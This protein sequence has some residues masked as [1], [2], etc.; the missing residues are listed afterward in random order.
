MSRIRTAVILAAG[1][2]SR[3]RDMAPLKPLCPVAGKPLI[4]HALDGLATAG[5]SRAIVILGYGGDEI[6]RHLARRHGRL[7]LEAARTPDWL[8]PNGVSVLAAAPLLAGE[9]AVLAMCDHLVTPDLYARL[10]YAGTGG[11]LRLGIDRRLGHPWIDPEDVTCVATRGDRITAIAKGLETFDAYDTGVFAIG[12]A[13]LDV[14][15]TLSSPSISQG[16]TALAARDLAFVE[17]CS[18]LAWLDVD[19]AKA[20]HAAEQWMRAAA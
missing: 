7:T 16:V 18:D 20:L 10:A 17:D 4:D 2:G 6:A 11:G 1:M 9:D 19:D 5:F 14:L 12:P 15:A 13:F 3:L 8:Q